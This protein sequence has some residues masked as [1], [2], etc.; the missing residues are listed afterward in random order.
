M[1][2]DTRQGWAL[3]G[4]M[5]VLFL[6][7]VFV[8]YPAEQAGNPV[9]AKLAW[10]RRLPRRSRAATWKARKSASASPIQ[11]CSR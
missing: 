4:A 5:T 6:A 9:L 11:R 1:V 2:K 7:G 3:L 8:V 10:K